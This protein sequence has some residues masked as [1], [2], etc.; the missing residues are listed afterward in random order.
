MNCFVHLYLVGVKSNPVCVK[1]SYVAFFLS[2]EE[3][4]LVSP[5]DNPQ[6]SIPHSSLCSVESVMHFCSLPNSFM[7]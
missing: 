5:K 2:G 7:Y 3:E 6:V 1:F 4:T